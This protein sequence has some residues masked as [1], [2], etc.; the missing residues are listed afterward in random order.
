MDEA[1]EITV[2]SS[3]QAGGGHGRNLEQEWSLPL[4]RLSTA[5]GKNRPQPSQLQAQLP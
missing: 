4:P 1:R 2:V 5:G 3:W